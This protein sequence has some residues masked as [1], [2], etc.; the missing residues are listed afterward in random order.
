[1]VGIG[2]HWTKDVKGKSVTCALTVTHCHSERPALVI[3][4]EAKNP[5]PSPAGPARHSQDPSLRV[6]GDR[7]SAQA[8]R[9]PMVARRVLSSAAHPGLNPDKV[10]N[11]VCPVVVHR[12][13]LTLDSYI[14]YILAINS[15]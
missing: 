8:V 2:V 15:Q 7:G 14:G 5:C 3:L 6:T 9:L 4:S 13:I 12:H 11:D 1:M 10:F